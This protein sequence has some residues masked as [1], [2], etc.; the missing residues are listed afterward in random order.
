MQMYLS[1]IKNIEA[2]EDRGHRDLF[3]C[4]VKKCTSER[5]RERERETLLGNNVH[6]G[7]V[8]GVAR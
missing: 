6:D 2:C 4:G 1:L 5:E 3:I 7:G 8:Q